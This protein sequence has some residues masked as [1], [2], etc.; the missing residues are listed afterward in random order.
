MTV[1]EVKEFGRQK[2]NGEVYRGAEYTTDFLPKVK[3]D[4]FAP[5]NSVPHMV[6]TITNSAKTVTVGDGKI[7]VEDFSSVVRIRTG[8]QGNA[9]YDDASGGV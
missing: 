1:T 2:G 6:K 5:D 4:M 7:F 9:H 8:R 3:I